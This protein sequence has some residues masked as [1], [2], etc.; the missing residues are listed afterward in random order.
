M[1]RARTSICVGSLLVAGTLLVH[2]C[3]SS[4][5]EVGTKG[6]AVELA[7][8]VLGFEQV[9]RWSSQAQLSSATD[10]F[11]GNG[12]LQITTSGYTEV[13][14][15]ALSHVGAVG[16]TTSIR[17]SPSVVPSWGEVRLIVQIPS[18]AEYW[19]DL[20]GEPVS[21]LAA[22]QFHELQFEVPGSLRQKMEGSYDDLRFMVIIN[23]PPSTYTLDSLRPDAAIAAPVGN[24]P[25]AQINARVFEVL[26][27]EGIEP[28]D[29]VVGSRD[30]LDISDRVSIRANGDS[31]P[32]SSAEGS[33][34]LGVDTTVGSVWAAGDVTVANRSIVDGDAVAGG[35]TQIASD[36]TVT[37]TRLSQENIPMFSYEWAVL[38]PEP[39][40]SVL[41]GPSEQRLLEPGSY[42]DVD[43]KSG[44]SLYLRAGEYFFDSLVVEPNAS[45]EFVTNEGDFVLYVADKFI[46][47]GSLRGFGGSMPPLFVGYSGDEPVLLERAFDGTLIAPNAEIRLQ[48]APDGGH[49]GAFWGREVRIEPDTE[50]DGES[51]DWVSF[52]GLQD[53]QFDGPAFVM[54]PSPVLLTARHGTPSTFDNGSVIHFQ[55]PKSLPVVDGNAGNHQSF[56]SFDDET[57]SRVICTYRGTST[58][59]Q[60]DSLVENARGST[61]T[62]EACDNGLV[63][64]DRTSGRNFRL[65]AFGAL[66]HYWG[67]LTLKLA[68]GDDPAN[69]GEPG[70]SGILEPPILPGDSVAMLQDFSWDMTQPLAETDPDGHP[71]LYSAKIYVQNRRQLAQLDRL[72]IHHDDLPI[73]GTE[74]EKYFGT[75]GTLDF[76]G[77]GNGWF[78]FAIIPGK[79]FNLIRA[80]A[81]NANLPEDGRELFRA[82]VIEDL[83]AEVVHV[84]TG[85]LDYDVLKE[86]GFRYR[87]GQGGLPH[88][89]G[90]NGVFNAGA[91]DAVEDVIEGIADGLR[92]VGNAIVIGFGEID[93]LLH[94]T[95]TT[96]FTLQIMNL[97]EAFDRDG[98]MQAGWSARIDPA[99]NHKTISEIVGL[100]RPILGKYRGEPVDRNNLR[101]QGV[102]VEVNGWAVRPPLYIAPV[103]ITDRTNISGQALM[104]IP[105][106]LDVDDW[107]GVCVTWN[108]DAAQ[109]TDGLLPRKF[110]DFREQPNLRLREEDD[111]KRFPLQAYSQYGNILNQLSEGYFLTE[112][113]GLPAPKAQVLTGK[114][115]SVVSPMDE[116]SDERRV[117]A[118]CLGFGG[119][120]SEAFQDTAAALNPFAELIQCAVGDVEC[121]ADR[122]TL[123]ALGAPFYHGVWSD[124][125]IVVP[126]GNDA[127]DSRGVLVHEYGHFVVCSAVDSTTDTALSLLFTKY[128]ANSTGETAQVFE[129]FA[130]FFAAHLIGASNYFL[131]V[132]EDDYVRSLTMNYCKQ[133]ECSPGNCSQPLICLDANYNVETVPEP[134]LTYNEFDQSVG[135]LAT[136]WLDAFDGY[137]DDT[138]QYF[139]TDA[140]GNLV[141]TNANI[142]QPDGDE[143]IH[144]KNEAMISFFFRWG[145]LQEQFGTLSDVDAA[146]LA[147]GEIVG[148]PS[149]NE[150]GADYNWCEICEL[151]AIHEPGVPTRRDEKTVHQRWEVCRDKLSEFIPRSL[152]DQDLRLSLD[153]CE[154]CPD[155]HVSDADGVC[156]PCASGEA[157]QGNVCSPCGPGE[158][159]N[160]TGVCEECPFNHIA[161]ANQCVSCGREQGANANKTACQACPV[162]AVVQWTDVPPCGNFPDGN[163][164]YE[165][166]I[167]PPAIGDVCPD[168]FWVTVNEIDDMEAEYITY[169]ADL[170]FETYV[171]EGCGDSQVLL[172]VERD[173]DFGLNLLRGEP[174]L[175]TCQYFERPITFVSPQQISLG[176]TSRQFVLQ[177]SGEE[178]W[179]AG[180]VYITNLI[181][182]DGT[183]CGAH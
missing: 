90:P 138:P 63:A 12:A 95:I 146:M 4:E 101:L 21:G 82:I 65:E 61:V 159:V 41:L 108:N 70:C 145:V 114:N 144:L 11:E 161:I 140:S 111:G 3:S 43:L 23:A 91:V 136:L 56:L 175:G 147:L 122:I 31:A 40:G 165:V 62:F 129:S 45:L 171:E 68:L 19:A 123:Q 153:S 89:L 10:V 125:D 42:G 132:H 134:L 80:A 94:E 54:G 22:N 85:S 37:G 174:H 151:F 49:R 173:P 76:S 149:L 143:L 177:A 152:P 135:R 141:T 17:F 83:P 127:L 88:N 166:A 167:T 25:Q 137:R 180:A 93:A 8:D 58:M 38:V 103:K 57:G 117:F 158:V 168:R 74:M 104:E 6:Q 5:S 148:E 102:R 1:I 78:V 14:S 172:M 55:I 34:D 169:G 154:T 124:S 66:N 183:Q 18:M 27:P 178:V 87:N 30:L 142:L 113:S 52:I 92:G 157:V 99:E 59:A 71:A 130:D 131:P 84:Q 28:I 120:V 97:D 16:E 121:E 179:P 119:L 105:K 139:S 77:D 9:S 98:E 53:D 7:G 73:I 107:D 48:P 109:I 181:E 86:V 100:G 110:C 13:K 20:G 106:K 118:P 15:V 47:R 170:T 150:D 115:A 36:A 160:E 164:T 69:A 162:D 75:C 35:M 81:L 182:T 29:S 128:I 156:V 126:D 32:I 46:N 33:V 2:G 60:P 26:L 176:K 67:D 39:S 72:Q 44:A 112:R 133:P 96:R 155:G 24:Q 163:Q 116:G 79:A 50:I 51:F 64:G